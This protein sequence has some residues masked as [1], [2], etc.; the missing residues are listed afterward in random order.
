MKAAK[1]TRI[2]LRKGYHNAP[3]SYRVLMVSQFNK[4]DQKIIAKGLLLAVTPEKAAQLLPAPSKPTKWRLV[5]NSSVGLC[6]T[7]DVQ[8][9]YYK[10]LEVAV[11]WKRQT[12][13]VIPD[14]GDPVPE[15]I[16]ESQDDVWARMDL[17][18]KS[19]RQLV[20]VVGEDLKLMK[21][22][23]ASK[24]A[25]IQALQ[26]IKQAD[27]KT[28]ATLQGKLSALEVKTKKRK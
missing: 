14:P 23:L 19:A 26:R 3:I 1:Q 17:I 7:F 5:K 20:G 18:H 21:S 2:K 28:I 4:E 8:I 16:L 12:S 6:G 27:D 25:Q 11:F 10:G 15:G 9:L 22:E 24:D 13:E